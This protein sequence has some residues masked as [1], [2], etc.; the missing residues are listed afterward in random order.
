[1]AN[2]ELFLEY[3]HK[4]MLV[5]FLHNAIA[6]TTGYQLGRLFHLPKADKR[7]LAIETGIQ[8]SGLGLLLIFTFFEGLGGMAIV[9]A[10]WGIWHII[11]GLT[12][13]YFWNR[14]HVDRT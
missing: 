13:A 8:N 3:I 10:W 11:S 5:V 7:S 1:M 2:F 9:A 14:K 6:L 12:I 4:V